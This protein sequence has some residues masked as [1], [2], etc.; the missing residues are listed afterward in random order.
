MIEEKDIVL[1]VENIITLH[2]VNIHKAEEK[3]KIAPLPPMCNLS[4]PLE[5]ASFYSLRK[6][7]IKIINGVSFIAAEIKSNKSDEIITL[8]FPASYLGENYPLADKFHQIW[9]EL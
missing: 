1:A 8:R 9:K 5:Y 6:A 7:H 2:K 3:G 4:K